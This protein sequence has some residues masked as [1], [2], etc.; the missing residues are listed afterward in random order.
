MRRFG[1]LDFDPQTR[2]WRLTR[3][4]ERVVEARLRAAAARTID[5]VPDEQ[6]VDVMSH[7]TARYRL[8]DP[9]MAAMLRRE[10]VFGTRSR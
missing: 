9:M 2:G 6:M 1:M 5:A 3:G 8:G 10:F 7:V 4:G